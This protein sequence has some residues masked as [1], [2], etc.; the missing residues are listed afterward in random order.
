MLESALNSNSEKR[1]NLILKRK[2]LE[3]NEEEEVIRTE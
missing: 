3:N 1:E 2:A